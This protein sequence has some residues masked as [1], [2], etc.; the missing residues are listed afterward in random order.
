MSTKT[1]RLAVF[2]LAVGAFI[3]ACTLG[4]QL[5]SKWDDLDGGIRTRRAFKAQVIYTVFALVGGIV[6][7]RAAWHMR[8]DEDSRL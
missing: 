2:A 5:P 8:G 1:P 4:A 7:F 6:L 3:L